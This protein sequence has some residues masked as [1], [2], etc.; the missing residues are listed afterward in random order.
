MP[1]AFT[2]DTAYVHSFGRCLHRG[3]LVAALACVLSASAGRAAHADGVPRTST[4]EDSLVRL[5]LE[6][7]GNIEVT[8]VSKTPE[9]L[10]RIPAAI[11]VITQDDIRRS[12]ATT[13]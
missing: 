7:L 8:T 5:T 11:Y 1:P 4:R 13:L 10:R 12:G 3:R 9:T 2:A 6:E